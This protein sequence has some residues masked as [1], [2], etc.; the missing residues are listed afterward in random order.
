MTVT[1]MDLGCKLGGMS[2]MFAGFRGLLVEKKSI[3][4]LRALI[5]RQLRRKPC[6]RKAEERH[7]LE[8]WM[9]TVSPMAAVATHTA[10]P[11]SAA[12]KGA[13]P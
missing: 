9:Y 6:I 3:V 8:A 4:W 13:S 12:R 2:V 7:D 10:V 11:S 5:E 1:R